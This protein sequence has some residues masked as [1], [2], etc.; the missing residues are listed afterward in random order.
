MTARRFRLRSWL[1]GV[2]V[3][4]L[5][6]DSVF[7][8][9][10]AELAQALLQPREVIDLQLSAATFAAD[11]ERD[12]RLDRRARRLALQPVLGQP[13]TDSVDSRYA[14]ADRRDRFVGC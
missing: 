3:S 11:A 13:L 14:Y 9:P 10:G 2:G 7:A 6:R 8:Q 5:G 12:T 4:R 1:P